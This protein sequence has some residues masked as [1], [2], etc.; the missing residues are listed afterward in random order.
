MQVIT[1][2]VTEDSERGEEE[3]A[4]SEARAVMRKGRSSVVLRGRTRGGVSS[5]V[6]RISPGIAPKTEVTT[7]RNP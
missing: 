1:G 5:A 6:V 7:G 2:R 3:D 4:S